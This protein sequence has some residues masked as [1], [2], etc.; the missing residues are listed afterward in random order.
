MV[1]ELVLIST[2]G[3]VAVRSILLGVCVYVYV[4]VDLCV[5]SSVC[6][7][8]DWCGSSGWSLGYCEGC[9]QAVR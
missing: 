1:L 5:V 7:W 8:L 2:V 4:C 3:R 9:D 6:W